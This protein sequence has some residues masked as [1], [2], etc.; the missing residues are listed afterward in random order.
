MIEMLLCSRN[1]KMNKTR[2]VTF[3]LSPEEDRGLQ[4]IV[5]ET[6]QT[7]SEIFRDLLAMAYSHLFKCNP[8]WLRDDDKD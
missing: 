8:P 3:R 7:V 1:L 2:T 6:G 4:R 5:D